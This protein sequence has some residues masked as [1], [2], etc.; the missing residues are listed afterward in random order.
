MADNDEKERDTVATRAVRKYH[1]AKDALDEFLGDPDIRDVLIEMEQLVSKHNA[2]LDAAMRAI[3]SELA[4]SDQTKLVIE[5]LGAQKKFKR[6]YDTDFL[7]N[8]LPAEQADLV[9]TEVVTYQLD[10]E[11]LEQLSRQGEIDNEIVAKA[12][13]EE[14]GNPANLPGTPKPYAVPSVPVDG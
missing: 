9:L 3:K 4:K 10:Q 14:E 6:Y 7:A 12:Y 5:G 8:A 11:L 13:H 2:A 1:D